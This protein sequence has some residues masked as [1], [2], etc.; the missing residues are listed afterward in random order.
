MKELAASAG[1]PPPAP[2][3]PRSPLLT[4][5]EGLQGNDLLF[6]LFEES[7]TLTTNIAAWKKTGQQIAKRTPVFQTAELLLKH[8]IAAALPGMDRCRADW[9]A[10][11]D[12]RSLLDDPDPVSPV[13]QTVST[14]LRNGLRDGHS[15]YEQVLKDEIAALEAHALWGTLPESKRKSLLISQGVTSHPVPQLSSEAEILASLQTCDIAGWK[16]RTAALP[17]RCASALAEAIQEAKPKARRIDLPRATIENAT[18]L[19]AWLCQARE[20]IEKALKD[21]PAII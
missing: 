17:T 14:A 12:H 3:A 20:T 8:G 21:G 15:H 19:E 2:E 4:E 11:R 16:T 18:E 10:V 1:G 9:E 7:A 13:L 5:L 6:R